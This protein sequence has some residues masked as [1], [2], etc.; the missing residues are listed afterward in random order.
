MT[1]ASYGLQTGV[2]SLSY[3]MFFMSDSAI[4]RIDP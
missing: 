4:A 2:Q 1:A 3:A